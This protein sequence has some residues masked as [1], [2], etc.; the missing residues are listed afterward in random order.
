[1]EW[2]CRVRVTDSFRGEDG[3]LVITGVRLI[4]WGPA[5]DGHPRGFDSDGLFHCPVRPPEPEPAS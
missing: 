4:D 5:E 2:C 1:M 3:V